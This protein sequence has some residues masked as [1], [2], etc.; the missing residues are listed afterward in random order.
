MIKW[1]DK[2]SVG[3][4][5][6]DEEHKKFIDIINKVIHAKQRIDN[7]KELTSILNEMNSY[8]LTHFANEEANMIKSNYPDYEN[9]KKEHQGFYMQLMALHD[10]V[11]KSGPQLACEILEHLKNWLVNHIE[12]TDRKYI[13]CFKEHGLK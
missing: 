13:K 3:L 8:V 6:I 9:H 1:D 4:S 10:S 7:S 12:G 2:Y 5:C 11:S